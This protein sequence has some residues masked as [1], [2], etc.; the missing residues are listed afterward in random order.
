MEACEDGNRGEIKDRTTNYENST[1][2]WPNLM[3]LHES[4]S[5]CQRS[6]FKDHPPSAA[7]NPSDTEAEDDAAED[8]LHGRNPNKVN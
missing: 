7:V 8:E 1:C 5:P 6:K 3:R 4:I 2:G